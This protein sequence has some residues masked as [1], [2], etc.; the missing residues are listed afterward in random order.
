MGTVMDSNSAL[1][2]FLIEGARGGDREATMPGWH[3]GP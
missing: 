1:S 3:E 2:V